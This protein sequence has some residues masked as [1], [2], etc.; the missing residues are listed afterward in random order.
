[1]AKTDPIEHRVR[2]SDEDRDLLRQIRDRLPRNVD[3]ERV[4]AEKRRLM[5]EQE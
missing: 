3:D 5:E 4:D 1:M 2:F